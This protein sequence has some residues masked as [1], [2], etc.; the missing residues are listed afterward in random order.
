MAL[1]IILRLT[2]KTSMHEDGGEV[3]KCVHTFNCIYWGVKT[4]LIN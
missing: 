4:N 2:K 1:L 3:V